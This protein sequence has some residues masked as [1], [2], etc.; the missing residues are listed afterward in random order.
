MKTKIFVILIVTA[1]FAGIV[2][3]SSLAKVAGVGAQIAGATG[4]IDKN[5]A[6]A[7]Y[8]SSEAIGSARKKS[9]PNRSI[10]SAVR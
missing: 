7:I 8:K 4:V 9:P 10:T 6:N 2:S 3:C 1:V 5:T